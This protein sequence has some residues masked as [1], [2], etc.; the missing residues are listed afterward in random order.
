MQVD[1]QHTVGAR[2]SNK[3]CDQFGRDRRTGTG[4]AV[5]PRIAEIGDDR[6]DALCRRALQRVDADQQFHKIVIGGKAGRL[7]HEHVFATNVLVDFDEHFFV[8][9]A[10]HAGIRQRH[11]EIGSDRLC[12][13]Q[14]GVSGKQLHRRPLGRTP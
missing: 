12:Q 4:F 14:V 11:F 1:G 5:L 6:G 13:R 3:V 2:N 10:A 8:G 9:K 7:E